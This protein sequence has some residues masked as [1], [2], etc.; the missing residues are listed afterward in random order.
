MK[1]TLLFIA[2]CISLQSFS[3]LN[4]SS[5][6][7]TPKKNRFKTAVQ[8]LEQSI[9]SI[10]SDFKEMGKS[11]SEDWKKT[12]A[13]AGGMLGLIATD[14]Y[15][16]GFLQDHIES[17]VDYRVPTYR[18]FNS[19]QQWLNDEDLYLTTSLFG[20][21]AGSLMANHEKGQIVATNA[22]KSLGYSF[23]ISHLVLKSVFARKRPHPELNGD[24]PLP[25][26]KTRNPW[27]FGN[28]HP[29]YFESNPYGTAF[30]SF[31]ATAYFA[32]AKVFQMEYDNYWI[33]YGLISV[34][35]MSN[36]KS[37]KHWVSDM[38]LG[39]LIG[40][41]IGKSVVKNSRKYRKKNKKK[42]NQ[43]SAQ[44]VKF[45]KTIVPQISA[46]SIGFQMIGSF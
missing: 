42:R 1:N 5:P 10:P 20:L 41:L 40:T 32:V 27:D 14:K 43:S 4:Q 39:G 19:N 3:Q 36:F 33:P 15:T 38:A 46:S 21:Y 6:S 23:L 25:Y 13:Y 35:F 16:T 28:Y 2:A 31:H 9:L 44:K 8:I 7:L 45:Q 29:V 30:P 34:L 11:V 24:E 17:T 18:L 26:S 22:I 12:A 37:H